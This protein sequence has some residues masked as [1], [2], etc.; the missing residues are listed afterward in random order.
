[1]KRNE[2]IEMGSI[3]ATVRHL[4]ITKCSKYHLFLFFCRLLQPIAAI[5]FRFKRLKTPCQ[6]AA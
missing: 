4:A 3:R 5:Q 6:Y 2:P 1:M